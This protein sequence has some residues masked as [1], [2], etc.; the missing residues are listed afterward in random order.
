MLWPGN[1]IQE[2]TKNP[3]KG[4]AILV[5]KNENDIFF[6]HNFINL[7]LCYRTT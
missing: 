1:S 3:F 7:F 2:S 4:A 5:K 6:I